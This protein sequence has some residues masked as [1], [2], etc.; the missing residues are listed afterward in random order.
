MHARATDVKPGEI[1]EAVS[2]IVDVMWCCETEDPR[3]AM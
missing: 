2:Q 3:Q 1:P